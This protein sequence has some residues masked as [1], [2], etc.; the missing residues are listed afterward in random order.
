MSVLWELAVHSG[1]ITPERFVA[2]TSATPAKLFN[3]YPDKGHIAVGANAD[4]L[5]MQRMLLEQMQQGRTIIDPDSPMLEVFLHSLMPWAQV[6]GVHHP[7]RPV[8]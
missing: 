6:D 1:L 3:L 8:P 5:E 7:R 2:L 4:E